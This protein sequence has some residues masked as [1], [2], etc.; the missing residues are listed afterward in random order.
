[1]VEKLAALDEP[2]APPRVVRQCSLDQ[3][4]QSLIKLI[5]DQDM[6]K[7]AMKSMEIG[8]ASVVRTV[9]SAH[10]YLCFADTKKMPLGKLSKLQ[11]AKG[12]EALEAIEDALSSGAPRSKLAELSSTFYTI[13]PHSFGRNVPPVMADHEMLQKKFDMLLVSLP[14]C[15]PVSLARRLL[16][17]VLGDIELAQGLERDQEKKRNEV[18]P[19]TNSLT[20]TSLLNQ[21]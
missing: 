17:Q 14:A 16:L 6:F 3:P 4:T 9:A 15:L 10:C 1:M 21:L 20:I 5:F 18:S 7:D 13:I 12:F 8:T 19:R 2:D 11:I